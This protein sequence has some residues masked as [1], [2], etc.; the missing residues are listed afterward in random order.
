MSVYL[1]WIE[2]ANVANVVPSTAELRHFNTA[3]GKARQH[4][5]IMRQFNLQLAFPAAGVAGKNIQDELGAVDDPRI[6]FFFY[7]A[8]LGKEKARGR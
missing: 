5:F 6:H 7:I 8:L 4:V 2:M 3:S 1:P